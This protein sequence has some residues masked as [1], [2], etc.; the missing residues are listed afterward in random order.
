[1]RCKDIFNFSWCNV[2]RI[3]SWRQYMPFND[4]NVAQINNFLLR[5]VL[6]LHSLRTW[7]PLKINWNDLLNWFS[8]LRTSASEKTDCLIMY[9]SITADNCILNDCMPRERVMHICCTYCSQMRSLVSKRSALIWFVTLVKLLLRGHLNS[10]LTKYN[11]SIAN[12]V[13]YFAKSKYVK[14]E[15]NVLES[16]QF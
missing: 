3:I 10:Y 15:N 5:N 6:K 8:S 16:R 12:S 7:R 4:L 2:W 13:V 11:F 1:M 9:K 14:L